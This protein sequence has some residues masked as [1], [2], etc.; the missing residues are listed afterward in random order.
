MINQKYGEVSSGR[1]EAQTRG[2][3]AATTSA[4]APLKFRDG[5]VVLKKKMPQSIFHKLGSSKVTVLAT[6]EKGK[7]ITGQTKVVNENRIMFT[8]DVDCQLAVIEVTAEKEEK[9]EGLHLDQ[10]LARLLMMLYNVNISYTDNSGTG[11]YGYLPGTNFFGSSNYTDINGSNLIAPGIPFVFGHQ[12]ENFGIKAAQ[13]GWISTD[14]ILNKPYMMNN[15]TRLNIRAK[16]VPFP[17]LKI[18]LNAN[19]TMSNNTSEFLIYDDHN[20]WGGFNKANSGNFSMSIISIGSSFEKLGKSAVEES[21]V[22]NQFKQNREIIARRLDQSR[23]SNSNFGYVPGTFNPKTGFPTGYGPAAQEVLIP[24]FLA[25][26]SGNSAE[27]VSLT[28]F[29]SAKFMMPNWRLQYSGMVNKI[30]GLKEIMKSMSISHDYRSTYNVGSYISK[31]TAQSVL[32][33]FSIDCI[34]ER[35]TCVRHPSPA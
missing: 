29:P 14:T 17:D 26:Y 24:A 33:T 1:R 16:V 15:N 10:Y 20:G 34:L 31:N 25:A 5:K 23:V 7:V 21:L 19:R 12:D 30:K 13:N 2:Q 32:F 11:L 3:K 22:W 27:T 35:P 9:K 4:N 8:P 6:D 28:P 18:E